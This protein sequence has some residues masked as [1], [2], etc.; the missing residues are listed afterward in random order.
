MARGSGDYKVD[1]GVSGLGPAK[2]SR[3]GHV[4]AALPSTEQATELGMAFAQEN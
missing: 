4:P 1:S 3:V 2:Y